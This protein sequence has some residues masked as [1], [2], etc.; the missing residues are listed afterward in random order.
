MLIQRRANAQVPESLHLSF[1]AI[2]D[3]V[4]DQPAKRAKHL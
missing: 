4:A 3:A 1:H 2:P